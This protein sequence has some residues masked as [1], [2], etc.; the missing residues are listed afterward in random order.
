MLIALAWRNII[1]NFRR[2][3][4]TV[5]AIAIGLA[6]LLF[7][8]GFNDGVHNNMMRNLQQVIVGSVQIH[9]DGFFKRPKL[10]RDMA[11]LTEINSVLDDL[12]VERRALRVRSFALAAGEET[13]RGL[14]MLGVNA[15]QEARTTRI[16]S[17]VSRGRFVRNSDTNACVIG[18][19][20][21]GNLKVKLGDDVILLSEDRFGSLAAEKFELVGIIESGEMGI[22]R[23]L[24]IVP[25]KFMQEM[26]GMENRYSE[27]VLQLDVDQLEPVTTI[28]RQQLE[29]SGF[30]VLRWY[31]M[32]PVMKE[33]VDLENGFYYIFLS[34]VLLIVA[35][36]VMNTVLMSML[37]RVREFGIMMALGCSRVHIALLVMVES[38]ML[39]VGGIITGTGL[40]MGLI[41][42][43]QQ[44]G[45]DMSEMM[46]SVERFYIDTV[47][48][49][50]IDSDHLL[51]TVLSVL[52][53]AALASL[54]PAWR[55][56]RLEPVEAIQHLG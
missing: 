1:R 2:S 38:L 22:D 49:T 32:Y 3:L 33:W 50:E 40:G 4:I 54:V 10:T 30:E 34:I 28:L 16:A 8:W 24:V 12:G 44:V 7:L 52:A 36:G 11:D 5:V 23:G 47:I 56:S 13:S 48:Y 15:D 29:P 18:A 45:I 26:L 37:D 53:S 27:V 31:D 20:T 21:A 51:I 25:L 9:E 35:A 41:F 43:Y 6:A 39:G 46:D 14:M 17:K 55:A 19:T 42:Y